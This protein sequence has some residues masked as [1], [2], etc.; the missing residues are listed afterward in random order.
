MRG[1]KRRG[2]DVSP[3]DR[4]F[5]DDIDLGMNSKRWFALYTRPQQ[6][7]KAEKYL[8]NRG[9]KVFVPRA[10]KYVNVAGQRRLTEAPLFR[11]YVFVHVEYKTKEYYLTL[12]APGVSTVIHKRGIPQPIPDEEMNSLIKVVTK[13]R[14]NILEHPFLKVG[15]KVIVVEGPL[16]GAVGVIET[17]DKS[18]TLFYVNI[19]ILK[20]S[21]SVP[22]HPRMV[23]RYRGG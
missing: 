20:R 18:K 8:K 15:Q 14:E 3:E 1:S 4:I 2:I 22:L 11:S 19:T 12:D 21:V 17:I 5:L 6:E 13:A 9:I 10:F 23:E 16:K 7:K